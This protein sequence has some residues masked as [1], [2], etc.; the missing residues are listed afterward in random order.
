LTSSSAAENLAWLG[1]STKT[2]RIDLDSFITSIKINVDEF[3]YNPFN[4]EV[5]EKNYLD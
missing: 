2:R 5:A 3:R 1:L 4:F